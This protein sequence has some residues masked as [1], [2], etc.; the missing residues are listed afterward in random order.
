MLSDFSFHTDYPSIDRQPYSLLHIASALGAYQAEV[1]LTIWLRNSALAVLQQPLDDSHGKNSIEAAGEKAFV[2]LQVAADRGGE[3]N[4]PSTGGGSFLDN[5]SNQA[6]K[7]TS[8]AASSLGAKIP[9]ANKVGTNISN[10]WQNYL[11]V[12][13]SLNC[14]WSG[15]PIHQQNLA[16]KQTSA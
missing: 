4:A 10:A 15:L 5:V 14:S 3:S 1:R 16:L 8:A 6:G 7:I 11:L 9:E 12:S 13:L 2:G